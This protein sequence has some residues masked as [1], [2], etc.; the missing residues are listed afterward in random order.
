MNRKLL[1]YIGLI[2]LVVGLLVLI[3]SSRPKPID[4]R[5]TYSTKD[6]IPLG[7]YVFDKEV[8]GIF[9][10]SKINKLNSTPYE[11]FDSLYDYKTK[12]YKANGSFLN[13]NEENTLDRESIMELIYFADHGNTVFLSMKDLPNLILDT[14][15]IKLS[16]AFSLKDTI[17]LS[18]PGKN[19]GKAYKFSQGAGETYFD[20]LDTKKVKILGYQQATDKRRPN[21]IKVPFGNGNFLLHTQPAAFSNYHMLKDNHAA[22]TEGLLSYVP[23]G[24][25]FWYSPYFVKRKE[26]SGN[27]LRYILA[28]PALKW[29][30]WLGLIALIIFV[31]FN[32]KRKQRVIPEIVPLRNT[33]VDF[34]RTV[35]NLYYQEG[36]HYTIIEKK[37]I[38]FLEKIRNEYT[39]DT[40]S[41]DDAFIEK[42]HL[43]TGK[44]VED[45]EKAVRLIKQHRHQF[46]STEAD[47]LAINKAIENLRL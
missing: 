17:R 3:D 1:L 33:T 42:L 14:L 20:S 29:A 22:Y 28:Q 24:D 15:N 31:F 47:V 32:A 11:Y 9:K 18:I 46:V 34:A 44:P 38:Y 4:W 45:I 27:K 36:N 26:I 5:P 6:K 19:G 41:L 13:V 37:I 43:K 35:G 16:G 21:F 25:V 30:M 8:Q 40:Y 7:L 23:D 12:H 2:A 39:I 10:G